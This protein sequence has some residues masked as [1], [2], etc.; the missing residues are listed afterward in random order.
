MIS[1]YSTTTV[2]DEI[3]SCLKCGG[4]TYE[5]LVHHCTTAVVPKAEVSM[6]NKTVYEI[7]KLVDNKKPD[8]R[9]KTVG[10]LLNELSRAK[11]RVHVLEVENDNLKKTIRALADSPV[12]ESTENSGSP[13]GLV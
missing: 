6:A 9:P 13:P 2:P 1:R 11:G 5:N 4:M 12:E 8:E 7:E 3:G 10:E